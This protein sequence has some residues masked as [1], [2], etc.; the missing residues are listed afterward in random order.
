MSSV[1]G[2]IIIPSDVEDAITDLLKTWMDSYLREMDRVSGRDSP[3][4]PAV[5]TW[6]LGSDDD[7]LAPI[8]PGVF[9]ECAEADMIGNADTFDASWATT[10]AV[11]CNS[12]H[13]MRRARE[14]VQIY[15]TNAALICVQQGLPGWSFDWTAQST[16]ILSAQTRRY[17]ARA[18]VRLLTHVP[19]VVSRDVGPIEPDDE[20]DE[21][22]TVET[23][24]TTVND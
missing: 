24:E 1:Y 13:S 12:E 16:G 21:Y 7:A 20:P 14:L 4:L 10:I 17:L 9:V 5:R 3:K 6:G 23:V 8:P 19:D 18:E 11:V 15:A 2:Q 22:P